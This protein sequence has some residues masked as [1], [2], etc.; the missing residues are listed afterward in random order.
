MLMI[1]IRRLGL[2]I[3]V[4]NFR[5]WGLGMLV[6][7][8]AALSL[9][10]AS[11]ATPTPGPST[12]S[13]HIPSATPTPSPPATLTP[14]PSPTFPISTTPTFTP[15][16]PAPTLTSVPT[17]TAT[18]AVATLSTEAPD[19]DLYELARSLL[20]KTT[21]PIPR[22]VN[23][24]PVAYTAGRLDTFWLTDLTNLRVYTS[25]ATLRLVSPRAYWY[26]EDGLNISL[27]DLEKAA[28]VFEEEIYPAVTGA[29]GT[30]W[31]P[32][33]DNDPHLTILHARLG[34]YS[35][36][37]TSDEYPKSVHRHSNQREIVYLTADGMRVGSRQYL[38]VLS[39]E[40][41]H[42][43]HW[44]GDPTEETWV[45]EGLAEVASEVAGYRPI[46]RGVFLQSPTISLINWPDHKSPY[47][48][49]A[50]NFFDYL[51]SH[52]GPR[53][54]L[55]ALVDEPGDGIQGINSYLSGLGYGV[56]FEDV[57]KDWTVANYL[58]EPGGGPYSYP[59]RDVAVRVSARVNQFGERESTIPQY[60]AEYTAVDITTGDIVVRFQGQRENALLPISLE[61]GSCWWGNR[62]DSISSTLTRTLDLS[63]V[64]RATLRY[65]TWFDIEEDW[66][67]AYVEVSTD[68]G[69]TWDILQAPG[70]S[71]ANPL[72]NSFGPGYTGVTGDRWPGEEVDLTLYA[73]RQV[74]L[75]FQY[76]TDAALNY[77]GICFDDISVEEV[78]FFDSGRVS[79]GWEAEGFLRIDNRVPQKYIVQVIEVGDPNRV[80]RMEL[81]D[82]NRGQLVVRGLENLDELVV[83]VAALAPKTL[84]DA[85]YSLAIEP[86]R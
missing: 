52:Y 85:S 43:V 12:P 49:A 26:V 32:G 10:C 82:E 9:G 17:P 71:S 36:F 19:S 65:R 27:Q 7:A 62:G 18:P 51:N 6:A 29:F 72:G 37:S 13:P 14:A 24:D 81:D 38:A 31:N 30:E 34:N 74:L 11:T 45:N 78:G 76:V 1:R 15:V 73:G 54:D 44:K 50:Y 64:Q 70:T 20:L 8:M 47:Y 4:P 84:L 5:I 63:D 23:P 48:S 42:A 66:D 53:H 25:Q 77:E 16:V 83:V 59:N 67:Y 41:Q 35:Y 86:A 79:D 58:D 57:F 61:G 21:E 75:R 28:S 22:V 39:H 68:G 40:L 33:V 80:R 69:S 3:L 60:S 56:T 2:G 46:H 55:K